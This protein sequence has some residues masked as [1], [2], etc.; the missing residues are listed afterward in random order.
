MRPLL[1]QLNITAFSV[2][3]QPTFPLTL[4]RVLAIYSQI[5][6]KFLSLIKTSEIISTNRKEVVPGTLQDNSIKSRQY[7]KGG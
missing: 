4:Q 6:H 3:T 7:P 1:K 2:R 5:N